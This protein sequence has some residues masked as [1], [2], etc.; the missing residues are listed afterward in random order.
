MGL[1]PALKIIGIAQLV[2][3]RI[4][5]IEDTVAESHFA[6]AQNVLAWQAGV[7]SRASRCEAF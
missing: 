5:L 4:V 3:R 7:A 2:Q 1:D 6:A